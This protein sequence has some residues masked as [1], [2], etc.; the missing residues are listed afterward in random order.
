MEMIFK[1]PNSGTCVYHPAEVSEDVCLIPFNYMNDYKNDLKVCT[2]CL[3]K[4]L[5][6]ANHSYGEMSLESE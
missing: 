4:T 1:R 6:T 3:K 2:D 5:H